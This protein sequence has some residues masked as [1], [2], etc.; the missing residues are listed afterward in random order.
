MYT[1]AQITG[2]S[3][4]KL[5]W[6][7]VGEKNYLSMSVH[8]LPPIEFHFYRETVLILFPVGVVFDLEKQQ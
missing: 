7:R 3:K 8:G 6:I 5:K 4:T 2:I 1:V